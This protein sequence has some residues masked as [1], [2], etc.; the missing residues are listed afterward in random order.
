MLMML[1]LGIPNRGELDLDL[2]ARE[3]GFVELAADLPRF[4]FYFLRFSSFSAV[5]VCIFVLSHILRGFCAPP[6]WLGRFFSF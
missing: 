5:C 2:D 1:G 3:R 4:D 6:S